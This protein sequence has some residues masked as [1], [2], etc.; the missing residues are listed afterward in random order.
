MF[1]INFDINA[2]KIGGEGGIELPRNHPKFY[3]LYFFIQDDLYADFLRFSEFFELLEKTI[4]KTKMYEQ[5]FKGTCAENYGNLHFVEIY[6]MI[7]RKTEEGVVK[8][9]EK[10]WSGELGKVYSDTRLRGASRV[11]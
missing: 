9:E 2:D 8:N 4:F 5:I 10:L 6:G 3:Y 1:D 11:Y 7:V